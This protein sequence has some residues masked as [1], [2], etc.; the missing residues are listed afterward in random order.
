M[1]EQF[2][3]LASKWLE[4]LWRLL[5]LHIPVYTPSRLAVSLLLWS[6]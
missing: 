6:Q 1:S 4:S 5:A 3:R 2:Q